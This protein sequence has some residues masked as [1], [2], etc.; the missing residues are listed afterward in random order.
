MYDFIH[1]L[2]PGVA[3]FQSPYHAMLEALDKIANLRVTGLL[4]E[5]REKRK[6]EKGSVSE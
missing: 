5:V 2:S 1:K 4:L 3:P 6:I